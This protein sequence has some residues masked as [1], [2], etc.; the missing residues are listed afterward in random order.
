MNKINE[1]DL[2][3]LRN[4]ADSQPVIFIEAIEQAFD[5]SNRQYNQIKQ[6]ESDMQNLNSKM[7]IDEKKY[8]TNIKHFKQMI[9]HQE[10][11]IIDLIST[12]D[13]PSPGTRRP[14][15]LKQVSPRSGNYDQNSQESKNHFSLKSLGNGFIS[16]N[17]GLTN[18]YKKKCSSKNS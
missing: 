11:E 7:L 10:K 12:L 8:N 2:E 6:L 17:S 14:M 13:Q 1:S 15:D 5:I 3:V 18:D 4:L 9:D 16:N